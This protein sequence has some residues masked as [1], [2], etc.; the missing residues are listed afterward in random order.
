MLPNYT[1]SYYN[2]TTADQYLEI[3][4]EAC[5]YVGVPWV[6]MR[7]TGI[8]MYNTGTYTGDGIHPNVSGMN[9]LYQKLRKFFAYSL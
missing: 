8:T 5:D 1:T 3:I 6:D 4:K 9:L 7:T 2:P